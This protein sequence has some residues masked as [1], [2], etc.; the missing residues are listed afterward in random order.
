VLIRR[1]FMARG[2][3]A[4]LRAGEN[5]FV[6]KL[7][8]EQTTQVLSQSALDYLCQYLGAVAGA[9]YVAE[10][11]G[12]LLRRAAFAWTPA[13][14][15]GESFKPREGL[16]GQAAAEKRLLHV[17]DVPPEH[18]PVSS[19]LGEHA[20]RELLVA[21]A[22]V[23]GVVT[24]VLELGFFRSVQRADLELL[25]LA[26]E[27]FGIA[28]RTAQ[29]RA[30][31]EALL[32]ETQRQS[33]ELQTQQEELRVS[34]EELEEQSRAL[35]ESQ[36]RLEIQ[37]NELSQSNAG[38]VRANQYKSEFLANM[39]H[40]LRTPLNSSLIL[41]KLLAE[42]REGNLT[43]EQIKFADTIYAAGND[44]LNLINDILDLSKIEAG[45][46]EIRSER[47][48]LRAMAE[49]LR[50][51]FQPVADERKLRFVATVEASAPA[52]IETDRQRMQQI[53]KNL[54]SNA[55][56]FTDAGE[57]S[58]LISAPGEGIAF[59][60]KDSGIG[61]APEHHDLVF[62]A[63]KQV[64]GTTS[65]KYGGTG[66]GLSISRDFARLLGGDLAL[67]SAPGKGSTFTLTLPRK[68]AASTEMRQQPEPAYTRPRPP[69]RAARAPQIFAAAQPG[70]AAQSHV[71]AGRRILIIE[72]DQAFA[73]A[74]VAIGRELD[75]DCLV[76]NT[77][78]SGFALALEELP[79]GIVLDVRLPDHSGLSVL[80]R[81][82]RN[83]KTRHIPVHV[84][85]GGDYTQA[86]LEMG[87]VG[88][89]LKPIARGELTTALRELVTKA[90]QKERRILI[91]ED[92]AVQRDSLGKLLA[93]EG[94]QIVDAGTAAEASAK[95]RESTYD[96]MV[97]DLSLPDQSGY[98]LLETMARDEELAFP[99]VIVYTGRSLDRD[100]EEKLRRFSRSIIIKGARSPERLLDEV[101]LFLHQVETK[102]PPERQRMLKEARDRESLFDGRRILLVEDDV[103]NIFALSRVLEPK[104]AHV[105]IARNGREALDHLVQK[106]GVDLILMDIM[107]PEMD[108]F[109]AMREIR[110]NP[111][112]AKLPIIALTAKAMR[113]DQEKCMEAGAND[114]VAKPIDVDKLLS[115][116]R[117]WLPR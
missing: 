77:A 111:E 68:H 94:V 73:D 44:L 5:G 117:V 66:L 107:M 26:G 46:M 38:L 96:C 50:K 76:A 100:E 92:D 82:K 10:P 88:Y 11:D 97:L 39:S 49:T 64:E 115:L 101:T 30:R 12:T 45:K 90:E 8:G 59:A 53:L 87:A 55:F 24:A 16:V 75:F 37:Q 106:P 27:P 3:E 98:Q 112:W 102:M 93:N 62:D 29:Y 7:P 34:N 60:V 25:E 20:V 47:I 18:A 52:D 65:R 79:S 89:A 1:D 99:P 40:E 110:K 114:Y 31:L 74:V 41:A 23:D 35:T 32:Q 70:A 56:K 108:G 15:E 21:P 13:P 42:N 84:V 36:A 104:G 91:V 105:E 116:L 57:V 33:E 2:L 43:A 9:A 72:D 113:D 48:G 80:D 14:G 103:R 67:V 4:W 54:L 86:A 28:L 85:S 63:F 51:Q 61:I 69:E 81:L 83:P 22:L 109:T 17:S 95:L 71:P 19:G 6:G 78:D 58:L